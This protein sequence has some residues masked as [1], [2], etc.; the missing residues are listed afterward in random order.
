MPIPKF[1]INNYKNWRSSNY[2]KSKILYDK[3]ATSKQK[4]TTQKR[5]T[6]FNTSLLC[7]V[8][9][10]CKLQQFRTISFAC[11]QQSFFCRCLKFLTFQTLKKFFVTEY[12]SQLF[13]SLKFNY[14]DA[15]TTSL[16]F[17]R[18]KHNL[19]NGS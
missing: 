19:G 14:F 10:V 9:C 4:P 3:A 16:L 18:V 5:K 12:F 6:T 17:N 7:H 1:L 2:N 11:S 8:M 13:K 15:N